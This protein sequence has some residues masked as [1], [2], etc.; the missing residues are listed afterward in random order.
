[1]L[2]SLLFQASQ[3]ILMNRQIEFI[4]AHKQTP[5]RRQIQLIGLFSAVITILVTGAGIYL[6]V[7]ASAATLGREIQEMQVMKEVL[8]Q[9]IE[10]QQSLLAA[11]TSARVMEARAEALGFEQIIPASATYLV[12][13]GYAGKQLAELAPPPQQ[14]RAMAQKLRPEYTLTL[15]DWVKSFLDQLAFDTG[16]AQ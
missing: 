3:R 10:D 4:Q 9:T 13:P 5:W 8:Q 11:M 14:G 2:L 15:F 16:A 7:T 6:Y 12:I 1:M